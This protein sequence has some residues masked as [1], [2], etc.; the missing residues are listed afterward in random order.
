MV[1][2][3]KEFFFLNVWSNL[4]E[5][6]CSDVKVSCPSFIWWTF[7]LLF[8]PFIFYTIFQ[9]LSISVWQINLEKNL[10]QE[11][12]RFCSSSF[13]P[14]DSEIAEIVR[15]RM[16]SELSFDLFAI[17]DV[18]F[19][20]IIKTWFTWVFW[21][22][23]GLLF[24][25]INYWYYFFAKLQHCSDGISDHLRLKFFSAHL[26]VQRPASFAKSMMCRCFTNSRFKLSR[27]RRKWSLPQRSS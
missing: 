12:C 16:F 17:F 14:E 10:R 11:V 24:G 8:L 2:F 26:F 25:I 22:C 18:D 4:F 9:T 19:A 27:I 1:I 21:I 7:V 5:T 3:S 6:S 13:R 23:R 15:C 20:I